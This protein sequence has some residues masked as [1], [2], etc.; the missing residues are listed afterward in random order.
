VA[1]AFLAPVPLLHTAVA[2][3]AETPQSLLASSANTQVYL[4]LGSAS[5]GADREYYFITSVQLSTGPARVGLKFSTSSLTLLGEILRAAASGGQISQV[6]LAFRTPGLNGRPT[7][8]SVDNF[9][10]AKVAAVKEQLSGAPAGTV[11]LTLPALSHVVSAPGQLQRVGPFAG[12]SGPAVATEA[13]VSME[14]AGGTETS[15]YAVTAV[16]FSQAASHDPLKLRFTTSSQPLLDGLFQDQGAAA[17]IP[18]LTLSIRAS[19]GGHPFTTAL[20]YS[21]SGVS[22]GAFAENLSGSLSGTT[23]LDI[24]S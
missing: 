9:G 1:S 5:S 2:R 3:R 4:K 14:T 20:T 23:T 6:S 17:S 7:T 18:Q 24:G 22:V 15:S 16:Q 13:R 19:A 10:A 11:S 8:E 12:L 21:F